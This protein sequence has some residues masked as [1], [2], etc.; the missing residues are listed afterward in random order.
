VRTDLA[1]PQPIAASAGL[2][3]PLS[4]RAAPS[5]RRRR[6]SNAFPLFQHER[7]GVSPTSGLPQ[8]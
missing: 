8:R 4:S 1:M 2:F 6:R 5:R 3:P 7:P